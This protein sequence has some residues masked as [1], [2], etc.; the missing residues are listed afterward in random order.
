MRITGGVAQKVTVSGQGPAKCWFSYGKNNR[1][2][3]VET[4]DR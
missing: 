2:M 1:V 3:T 4:T